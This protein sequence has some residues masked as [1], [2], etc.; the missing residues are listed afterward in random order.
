MKTIIKQVTIAEPCSQSWGQMLARQ[1]GQRFCESCQKCVIDFSASSSAEIRQTLMNSST[2]ICGRLSQAQLNELNQYVIYTPTNRN[3]MK[4][5]GVLAIGTGIF[6]QEAQAILP[7]HPMVLFEN[8]P[9]APAHVHPKKVTKIYGFIVDGDKKPLKGIKVVILNTKFSD[10]TDANGR[11]EIQI[12]SALKTTN[13]LL[14]V[15]TEDDTATLKLDYRKEKQANLVI[16]KKYMIM[17][18]IAMV[19]PIK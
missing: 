6:F 14:L 11:Y 9:A 2:E 4:Y 1:N 10:V 15:Q 17:G 3:W 12:D 5:L 7:K 8:L 19:K 13:D 16:E 18:K